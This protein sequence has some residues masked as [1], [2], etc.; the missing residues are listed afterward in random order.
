MIHPM[1]P[2]HVKFC[3]GI[4]LFFKFILHFIFNVYITLTQTTT[5]AWLVS[6]SLTPI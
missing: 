6:C 1:G 4:D 5:H 3:V 2:N